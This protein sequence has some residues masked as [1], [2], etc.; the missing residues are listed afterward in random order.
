MPR[1]IVT[2]NDWG[3][4]GWRVSLYQ[5]ADPH[6][7]NAMGRRQFEQFCSTEKAARKLAAEL[8]ANNHA[9]LI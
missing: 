1:M 6:D 2:V 5:P 8:T 3:R 4:R 7:W 9:E